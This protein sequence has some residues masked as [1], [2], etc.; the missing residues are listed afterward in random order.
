MS[1]ENLGASMSGNM[2]IGKGVMRTGKGLV[3]TGT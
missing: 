3:R 1:I 2:L